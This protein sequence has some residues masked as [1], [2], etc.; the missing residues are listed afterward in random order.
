MVLFILVYGMMDSLTVDSLFSLY[1]MMDSLTV[2]SLLKV[3][4]IMA[5]LI[6]VTGI[7]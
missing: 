5:F 7:H 1:G 3:H 2:D 6:M 4:G